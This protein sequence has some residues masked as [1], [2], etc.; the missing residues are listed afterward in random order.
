MFS[1]GLLR[2]QS[3]NG[4]LKNFRDFLSLEKTVETLQQELYHCILA[5]PSTDSHNRITLVRKGLLSYF[6]TEK[7]DRD[8]LLPCVLASRVPVKDIMTIKAKLWKKVTRSDWESFDILTREGAVIQEIDGW[9]YGA[10]YSPVIHEMI[11]QG[12]LLKAR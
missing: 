4:L 6:N 2:P 1:S 3:S 7:T 8:L 5:K 9:L 11:K 12:K 10:A